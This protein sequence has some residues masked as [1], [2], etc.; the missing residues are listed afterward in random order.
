MA[1]SSAS[2]T[3][4]TT[5][6]C[7]TSSPLARLLKVPPQDFLELGVLAAGGRDEIPPQ[8]LDHAPGDGSAQRT[9]RRR[10]DPAEDIAKLVREAVQEALGA[11]LKEAVRDVVREEM[12]GKDPKAKR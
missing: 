5:S 4:A 6:G 7:A 3:A 8:R 9:R 1:T 10:S 12:D 11:E 2:S